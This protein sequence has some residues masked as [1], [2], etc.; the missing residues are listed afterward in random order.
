M[1][2]RRGRRRDHHREPLRRHEGE[3]DARGVWQNGNAAFMRNWPYA[4]SLGN[5]ADSISAAG[6]MQND[7]IIGGGGADTIDPGLGNDIVKLS[8]GGLAAHSKVTVSFDE[9]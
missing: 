7:S 4:W 1:A 2:P 5:G 8:L 9:R 3:E 6:F